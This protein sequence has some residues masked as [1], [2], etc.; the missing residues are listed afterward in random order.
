MGLG[1]DSIILI[2]VISWIVGLVMG[3]SCAKS[4]IAKDI[5]AAGSF[6][7]DDTGYEASITG[8]IKNEL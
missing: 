4:S 5:E 2:I 8:N 6:R 7:I 1:V 3:S